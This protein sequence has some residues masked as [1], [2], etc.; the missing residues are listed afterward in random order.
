MAAP[1]Y[2]APQPGIISL[3]VSNLNGESLTSKQSNDLW[4]IV[5]SER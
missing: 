3:C 1:Q 5:N 4:S 2:V